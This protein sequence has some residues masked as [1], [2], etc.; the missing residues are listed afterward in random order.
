VGPGGVYATYSSVLGYAVYSGGDY[1][2]WYPTADREWLD[3][4]R[5]ILRE[6]SLTARARGHLALIERDVRRRRVTVR[7]LVPKDIADRALGFSG[8]KWVLDEVVAWLSRERQRF[9]LITGEPGCGKSALAAW[10]AG[11]GDPSPGLDP[12]LEG[13][14]D[15]WSAVHFCVAEDK[16]GSLDPIAFTQ[17]VV[18]Q[19]ADRYSQFA[20]AALDK[21]GTTLQV[22]QYAGENRG[23]MVAIHINTLILV[24]VN[25]QG[26]YN[27]ALREPLDEWLPNDPTQRLLILVDALDEALTFGQPSIVTLLAGSNDL[28]SRVRF[29]LTSRN[30]PLVTDQFATAL[31]NGTAYRL[32]LSS[33]TFAAKND[34]DIRV[35]I[36]RRIAEERLG[37]QVKTIGEHANVVC[38]LVSQAA[39]NFLYI[40]FLL[41]EVS[42][43]RPLSELA[44]LPRGLYVLYRTYLDRIMLEILVAGS[45][46]KWDAQYR[47]L[48]GDLSV[49]IP[50]APSKLLPGWLDLPAGTV[51][52]LL[53]SV[54][55][56]VERGPDAELSYRLYHRSVNEF[57]AAADFEE[58]GTPTVNRYHAPPRDHHNLIAKFY[59]ENYTKAW[60]QCDAYG[61]RNLV[62]HMHEA[63]AG[64]TLPKKRR[65]Q[66]MLLFSV[67]R[68]P[69]FRRAQ[70]CTLGTIIG[71]LGDLQLA[72][73]VALNDN[74]L[75][76][77]LSCV[78]IYRETSRV[79]SVTTGIFDALDAGDLTTAIQRSD[80]FGVSPHWTSVLKRYL[81][82]EA[83]RHG[84]E[85]EVRQALAV[86]P[87]MAPETIPLC[88]ALLV[89]T[90]RELAGPNEDPATILKSLD[91][92]AESWLIDSYHEGRANPPDKDAV[93]QQLSSHLA[94]LEGLI[95][96]GDL[97]WASMTASEKTNVLRNNAEFAQHLLVSLAAEPEGRQAIDRLLRP[98]LENAYARYRDIELVALGVASVAVPDA[99]WAAER[100][101]RIISAGLDPAGVTFTFDL[102][103]VL[104]AEGERR[105]LPAADLRLLAEY[106]DK[107][108]SAEDRW[109]T[110]VRARSARAAAL[111]R[112][113]HF[114]DAEA[115]LEAVAQLDMGYAGFA[116]VTLLSLANRWVEF[117]R[118]ELAREL[119]ARA[120][121]RAEQVQDPEFRRERVRLV[122]AYGAWLN[123]PTPARETIASKIAQMP[124]PET[125]MAY[126]E[127]LSARWS[128]SSARDVDALRSL[129]PTSLS[130]GTTLDAVLGHLFGIE[131]STLDDQELD[132]VIHICATQLS[133][134]RP[135][136]VA[137][138]HA[139]GWLPP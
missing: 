81:A 29:L 41:D 94:Y 63:V 64:E 2:D 129:V 95:A 107:A 66:L 28:P 30:D 67:V 36:E 6:P 89:R 109:G 65:E 14:R 136:V 11:A 35:Y 40:K 74:D 115:E 12:A 84:K 49:A 26:V 42:K 100:L 9:L 124:D 122:D 105:G 117:G 80:I 103:S 135:W 54:I 47:P 52:T 77:A 53:G 139:Q 91:D 96:G 59:L 82:W 97:E 110:A 20:T 79:E 92:R 33:G 43:G 99:D 44:G 22:E 55:Q 48:L 5:M 10:L 51:A 86:T 119:T 112:Q 8:R 7:S 87:W 60:D 37:G 34:E 132:E 85:V 25:A 106:L 38:D 121:L 98:T 133:T 138:A 118:P 61:L 13:I 128:T 102:A 75:V 116:T 19:L 56:M 27:R 137:R 88:D 104:R 62:T 50:A 68:D 131:A 134:S 90:A 15:S 46:A 73:G 127:H 32:D 16:K 23:N 83:A 101:Q 17:S 126:V 21:Y 113:H 76:T 120:S 114:G 24:G 130:D 4:V 58:N 93:V 39:G 57:L 3:R 18:R 70:R 45:R 71:T 78:G 31:A 69:K 123:E 125:R 111:F 1:F 72:L 108:W